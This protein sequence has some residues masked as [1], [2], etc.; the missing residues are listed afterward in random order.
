MLCTLC[1]SSSSC[2]STPARTTGCGLLLGRAVQPGRQPQPVHAVHFQQRWPSSAASSTPRRLQASSTFQPPTYHKGGVG[3][4]LG[5]RHTSHQLCSARQRTRG[6]AAH[7]LRRRRHR[8]AA[9]CRRRGRRRGHGR[10]PSSGGGRV[11][12]RGSGRS[13]RSGLHRRGCRGARRRCP[14]ARRSRGGGR[15]QL[16]PQ[17]HRRGGAR[18]I[19]QHTL[20]HVGDPLPKGDQHVRDG[21]DVTV[22]RVDGVGGAQVGVHGRRPGAGRLQLQGQAGE[23]GGQA[24]RLERGAAQLQ[25]V[26]A[27]ARARGEGKRLGSGARRRLL[28]SGSAAALVARQA[29][30]AQLQRPQPARRAAR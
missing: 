21:T 19:C 5:R 23:V 29:R 2:A 9:H 25:A 10:A 1:C 15:Q 27:C 18:S 24:R 22:Q 16:G 26:R 20:C 8:A 17:P 11:R 7:Q 30:A 28:A 14:A 13:G 3:Q 12:R 4:R 6:R